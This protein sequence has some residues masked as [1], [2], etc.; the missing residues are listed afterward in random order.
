MARNELKLDAETTKAMEV[1]RNESAAPEEI[2]QDS[3]P[4]V[5]APEPV[6][7]EEPAAKPEAEKEQ[8]VVEKTVP[9]AALQ[10]TREALKEEKRRNEEIQ[11][12]TDERLRLL[13]EALSKAPEAT[14]P[15]VIPDPDKD[16]LGALKTHQ[17]QLKELMEY[18]QRSEAQQAENAQRQNIIS[19]A[20]QLEAQFVQETPD[21]GNAS[22]FLIKS[23]HDELMATG[24]YTPEQVQKTI[25]GETMALAQQAI[26]NGTNPAQIIYAIAKARGY[27]KAEPK[28]EAAPV[29]DTAQRLDRI[30]AGQAA[31][32]SVGQALGAQVSSGK[33]MDGKT[34]ANMSDD[35]F[36]KLYNKL[37]RGE[38]AAL[39]G[40]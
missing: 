28:T 33:A 39:M 36:A 1:M 2:V 10:E 31:S 27:T 16:A 38:R 35:D 37:S 29:E 9:L 24:M 25:Q 15:V 6:K 12:R 34:L 32:K 20:Q 17:Q 21:Y 30:A 23:R 4:E 8:T 19:R 11:R 3:T 5:V 40:A 22:Q 13:T 7:V 14:K 18:K 26:S